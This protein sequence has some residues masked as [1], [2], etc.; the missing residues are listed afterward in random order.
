L[1]DALKQAGEDT[2]QYEQRLQKF[3]GTLDGAHD[4]AEFQNLVD[5]MVAETK[6]MT[7]HTAKLQEQLAASS[8]EIIKLHDELDFARQDALTDALTGL[9]N[10][11]CFDR[12]LE[13]AVA[14]ALET[15]APLAPIMAD[16]DNFKAF[17]DTFGHTVGDQVLRVGGKALT[18][19][20][21]G[22]DIAARYGGEEF[23]IILPMTTVGGVAAL[24]DDIRTTIASKKLVKKDGKTDYGVITLSLGGTC[25][26]PGEPLNEF[27]DRADSALYQAKQYGRNRV[28]AV[29][30]P[31]PPAAAA[32]A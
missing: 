32:K 16:L 22:A 13:Q 15:D 27:I 6:S 28:M 21:K 30:A 29:E 9:A 31:Q 14:D 12:K 24:A 8:G 23:G 17:N 19:R 1:F 26:L 11:K 3:S 5:N 18:Q 25:Y 10:R 4:A 7:S 2:G 20:V